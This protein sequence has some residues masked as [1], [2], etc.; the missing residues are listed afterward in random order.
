[1]FTKLLDKKRSVRILSCTFV[2]E[3]CKKHSCKSQN[4]REKIFIETE[5]EITCV[6]SL[7]PQVYHFRACRASRILYILSFVCLFIYYGCSVHFVLFF[8]FDFC[9]SYFRNRHHL[10]ISFFVTTYSHFRYIHS[11]FATLA[12]SNGHSS[13]SFPCTFWLSSIIFPSHGPKFPRLVTNLN[14]CL[15]FEIVDPFALQHW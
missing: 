3:T 10:I 1:M 14:W 15:F 6:G 8:S 13:F 12:Y 11:E 7:I 5:P 4:K 2:K 9:A